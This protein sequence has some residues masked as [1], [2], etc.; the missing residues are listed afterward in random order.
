VEGA[1]P[2]D[3]QISSADLGR[4]IIA[5]FSTTHGVRARIVMT[6]VSEFTAV[7]QRVSIME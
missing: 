5:A 3:L 7:R 6:V 4:S 2:P 1:Q